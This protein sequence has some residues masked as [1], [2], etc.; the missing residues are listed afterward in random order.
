[1]ARYMMMKEA[2]EAFGKDL[3]RDGSMKDTDADEKLSKAEA[4]R[5]EALNAELVEAFK[6][7][8]V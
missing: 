4:E 5:V 2:F 3:D 6:G 8:V 7:G 1:M